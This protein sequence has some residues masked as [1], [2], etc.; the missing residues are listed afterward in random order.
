MCEY[1]DY[2]VI[3]LK[4]VRIINISLDVP[5]GSYREITKAEMDELNRLIGES[6]KTE[7]ASLPKAPSRAN[8]ITPPPTRDK[9]TNR[10]RNENR[11]ERPIRN[12][13][14]S[15]ENERPLRNERR[16]PRK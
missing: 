10:D 14:K 11:T 7:E 6:S 3:A 5:V 12:E 13:R 16:T 8:R 1:L 2:E 4:R 15:S 9:S